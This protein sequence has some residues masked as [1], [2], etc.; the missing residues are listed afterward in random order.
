MRAKVDLH[1]RA[2]PMS[3]HRNLGVITVEHDGLT[4]RPHQ[5]IRCRAAGRRL[6]AHITSVRRCGDHVP[7]V[8]ADAVGE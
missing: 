1:L 6:R 8:Y 5:D 3:D 2:S 4:V 7:H